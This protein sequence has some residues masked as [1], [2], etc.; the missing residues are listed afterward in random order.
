MEK[1]TLTD[2]DR[3]QIVEILTR[4]SNEI[5]IFQREVKDVPGSVELALQREIN[6]LRKL[7]DK[8]RPME[9]EIGD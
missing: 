6:R 5:A 9:Q 1:P 4:R 2:S 7:A 8:V 3:S